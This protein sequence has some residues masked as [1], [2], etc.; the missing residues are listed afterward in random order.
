MPKRISPNAK[1]A[2]ACKAECE[3][4]TNLEIRYINSTKGMYDID[5]KNLN[6][7]KPNLYSLLEGRHGG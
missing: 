1:A 4:Y 7:V 6:N 5:H 2:Q 3:S